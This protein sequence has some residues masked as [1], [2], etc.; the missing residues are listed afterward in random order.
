MVL[1]FPLKTVKC[2]VLSSAER[3]MPFA[4][5]EIKRHLIDSEA[6]KSNYFHL[7]FMVTLFGLFE[8]IISVRG[9]I[10]MD[11]GRKLV[12]KMFVRWSFLYPSSTILTS[13]QHE[14]Q[15]TVKSFR[16]FHSSSVID[17]TYRTMGHGGS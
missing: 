10:F 12:L 5:V 2:N 14:N 6:A 3:D 11:T 7:F 4:A 8:T 16:Q 15:P 13:H 1:Y 17:N 9:E